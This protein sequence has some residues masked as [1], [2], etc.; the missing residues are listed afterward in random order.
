MKNFLIS[1]V[2]IFF[3]LF[4]GSCDLIDITETNAY[5]QISFDTNG[6]SE[7]DAVSVET[8]DFN[9]DNY[10]TTKEGYRF[11]GWYDSNEL[12]SLFDES[13]V[14]DVTL[15]ARWMKTYTI[16]FENLDGTLLQSY[17]VDEGTMPVFDETPTYDTYTFDGSINSNVTSANGIIAMA[18]GIIE[19]M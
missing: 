3:I 10:V 5:Y 18:K 12:S 16:T 2:V 8:A 4:L 17:Q 6:G 7:I 9:I 1:I 13:L 14:S 15:Y 19:P 11:D